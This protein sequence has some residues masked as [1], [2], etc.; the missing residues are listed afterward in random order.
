MSP[1]R[2]GPTEAGS[3]IKSLDVLRG[4]ALLGILV[5]N[6]QLFAMPIAA[7]G[8]PT[9]WGDLSGINLGIWILSDLLAS[10]KFLTLFS[11]LFGAG[12]CLFADR[13]EARG[14][15]P[16]GW[17]YRRMGWLLAFG[18]A[19]AYLLWV[20]DILAPYAICGCLVYLAR[21]WRPRT[22]LVTGLALFSVTSLLV[23]LVGAALLVPGVPE[24]VTQEIENEWA[25]DPSALDA[26]I[27]AYGGGWRQ[28]QPLRVEQ[29]LG[30]H[31]GTVPFFVLWFCGGLM[32]IGM[33]LYKWGVLSAAKDDRFYRRLAGVWT[34]HRCA[35]SRFRDLVELFRRLE[36][37]ALD[38]L[39]RA[40]QHLGMR[41]DG[42]RVLG[43]GDARCPAGIPP[44]LPGAAGRGRTDGLHELP[45]P[46]GALHLDLLRP[47]AGSLRPRRE[48]PATPDRRRGVGVPVVAVPDLA[49]SLLLRAARV[50]LADAHLRAVG[51]LNAPSDSYD[52][53]LSANAHG[54]SIYG[55]ECY[56][57]RSDVRVSPASS[58][59]FQGYFGL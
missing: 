22:L 36:L 59:K 49:A 50:G 14:G 19:H 32:L 41:P 39:R 42:A 7:Y 25:P 53:G 35:G 57:L 38:V 46:D 11:L 56:E 45:A 51:S 4:F 52:D 13:I 33:A 54:R 47:R 1:A 6:I 55:L 23:L 48:V 8:N 20:G 37:A 28:Q 3:R 58:P 18:L 30:V 40:V 29:A 34:A 24:E 12:I 5:M 16:A 31:L 21:R 26:E 43:L 44:G 2:S 10:Q 15:R 27:A 17:H 9:A